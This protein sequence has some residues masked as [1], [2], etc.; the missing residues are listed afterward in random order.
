M[1][2]Q[3]YKLADIWIML[4]QVV[5]SFH[6]HLPPYAHPDREWASG[7]RPHDAPV[8]QEEARAVSAPFPND[9]CPYVLRR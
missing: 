4:E 1:V 8:Q 2:L 6:G 9:L 3:G 5:L 7:P